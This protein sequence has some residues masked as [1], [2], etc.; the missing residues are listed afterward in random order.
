MS[1]LCQLAHYFT[2][3]A[4]AVHLPWLASASIGKAFLC[5]SCKLN[6]RNSL[7]AP[8]DPCVEALESVVPQLAEYATAGPDQYNISCSFGAYGLSS[9]SV[10]VYCDG[11]GR[12][13]TLFVLDGDT[14][15]ATEVTPQNANTFIGSC[16][17]VCSPNPCGAGI[18]LPPRD[19]EGRADYACDC[20]VG[21]FS[22]AQGSGRGPTCSGKALF[23]TALVID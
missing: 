18:C 9:T 3:L 2:A 22:K 11:R 14:D 13:V 5:F 19:P 16:V 17:E 8:D 20:E 6:Y 15:D 7:F 4:L 1:R 23:S 12:D 21:Y 10:T